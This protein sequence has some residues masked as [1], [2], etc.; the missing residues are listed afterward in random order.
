[1]DLDELSEPQVT[2]EKEVISKLST[3]VPGPR[4]KGCFFVF[5]LLL[6]NIYLSSSSSSSSFL[7]VVGC[8]CGG[9]YCCCCCCCRCWCDQISNRQVL[10]GQ[11]LGAVV[12]VPSSRMSDHVGCKPAVYV[13]CVVQCVP[14]LQCA[15]LRTSAKSWNPWGIMGN[16][17]W[18]T[19][20]A[21]EN[22]HFLWENP[23]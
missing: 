12:A 14:C 11:L 5:I 15:E 19:N 9:G 20:I 8:G 7:L 22:H 17:L 13:S 18:W 16:T 10:V 1:M 4:A 23:L 6:L 3:L 2:S 21:M